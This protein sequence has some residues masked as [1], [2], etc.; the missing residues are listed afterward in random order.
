ML[1]PDAPNPNGHAVYYPGDNEADSG[2]EFELEYLG[3]GDGTY[4]VTGHAVLDSVTVAG[5]QLSKMPIGIASDMGSGVINNVKCDGIIGFGFGAQSYMTPDKTFME[6]IGS[7][8]DQPIFA[9]DLH[10]DGSGTIEL[11]AIDHTAYSGKLI[12]IPIN[13]K[14]AHW[15]VDDVTFDFNDDF[16]M[17]MVFGKNPQPDL[18]IL[19]KFDCDSQIPE[20]TIQ[21]STHRLLMHIGLKCRAPEIWRETAVF[22]DILAEPY[23]QIL[24]ST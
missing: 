22:G 1:G 23:F 17:P 11:G 3:T 20:Q 21:P 5:L 7:D 10:S 24:T 16:A 2:E 12:K 15:T 6:S 8:L 19:Q 9:L 18:L 13:S 14:T 4:Y